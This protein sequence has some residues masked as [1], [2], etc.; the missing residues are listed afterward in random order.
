MSETEVVPGNRESKPEMVCTE[1]ATHNEKSS[2]RALAFS[3]DSIMSDQRKPG[4]GSTKK[5]ADRT[6][7]F[8]DADAITPEAEVVAIHRH[9]NEPEVLDNIMSNRTN[10]GGSV[11]SRSTKTVDRTA[12]LG[13]TDAITPEPEVAAI[14]RHH[15]PEV[16]SRNDAVMRYHLQQQKMKI[17]NAVMLHMATGS[18]MAS[19]VGR[20]FP[21]ARHPETEMLLR[22]YQRHP[23]HL[24]D[25]YH[26]N[27]TNITS[28]PVDRVTSSFG[29]CR[30][31]VSSD[32]AWS[33]S[34]QR[35]SEYHSPDK[36]PKFMTES[37]FSPCRSTVGRKR[38]LYDEHDVT[39]DVTDWSQ[40]A[41]G[42]LQRHR[43][44]PTGS[45]QSVISGCSAERD[46]EE[47]VVDDDADDDR[48]QFSPSFELPVERGEAAHDSGDNSWT[49]KT[50]DRD[51]ERSPEACLNSTAWSVPFRL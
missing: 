34:K 20:L 17:A 11:V 6:T 38:R 33:P 39:R 24:Q 37:L 16:L 35:N 50:I 42:S 46:E 21:A 32:V 8:G 9:H 40:M 45:Q 26:Q 25:R 27:T 14:H 2:G 28:F 48:K 22:Q 1:N 18:S 10:H 5:I 23:Y 41:A 49:G 29:R 43:S 47:I 15:K 12:H 13:D 19:D 36:P 4:V 3:I 31:P 30:L 44:S 51:I 7:H